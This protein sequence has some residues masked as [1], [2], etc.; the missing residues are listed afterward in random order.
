MLLTGGGLDRSMAGYNSIMARRSSTIGNKSTDEMTRLFDI[1]R[2]SKELAVQ[3]ALTEFL[4]LV[5][6]YHADDLADIYDQE[7]KL[8]IEAKA[9]KKIVSRLTKLRESGHSTYHRVTKKD[10]K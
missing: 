9:L 3:E 5:K 10:L 8:R 4:V 7:K 1:A 2:D 6:L